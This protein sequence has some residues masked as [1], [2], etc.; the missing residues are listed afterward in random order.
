MTKFKKLLSMSVVMAQLMC[1][2]PSVSRAEVEQPTTIATDKEVAWQTNIGTAERGEEAFLYMSLNPDETI[3]LSSDDALATLKEKAD[4]QT[5]NGLRVSM[6]GARAKELQD[7]AYTSKNGYSVTDATGEY[8][9][10]YKVDADGKLGGFDVEGAA[11]KLW[12]WQD[13]NNYVPSFPVNEATADERPLAVS[14]NYQIQGTYDQTYN[15]TLFSLLGFNFYGDHYDYGV[16]QR[17]FTIEYHDGTSNKTK[18]IPIKGCTTEGLEH[19]VTLLFSPTP[20]NK[21]VQLLAVEHDG[22][23]TD[24]SEENV[25]G[26][27]NSYNGSAYQLDKIE[28]RM[29]TAT[30]AGTNYFMNYTDLVIKRGLDK[31]TFTA[32]IND[33]DEIGTEGF[34][35]TANM[36]LIK[37]TLENAI[38]VYDCSAVDEVLVDDP[39][40][41]VTYD[42][43][44]SQTANISFTK[45]GVNGSFRIEI[46]NVA[47]KWGL[48]NSEDYSLNF[49][50]PTVEP[51]VISTDYGNDNAVITSAGISI[52]ATNKLPSEGLDNAVKVY[53]MDFDGELVEEP[54]MVIVYSEDMLSAT[55]TF[56]KLEPSGNYKVVIKD[57]KDVWDQ[58][59]TEGLEILFK[60][61]AEASDGAD[62]GDSAP[63]KTGSATSVD[64]GAII[65]G[66][67]MLAGT[68]FSEAKLEEGV[69]T[70]TSDLDEW[71]YA[72]ANKYTKD[73][74]YW[75][76]D[77]DGNEVKFS[78][79]QDAY[80][81][82][83]FEVA[84]GETVGNGKPVVLSY[85]YQSNATGTYEWGQ[86]TIEALGFYVMAMGQS[87]E[88]SMYRC[89]TAGGLTHFMPKRSAT[90]DGWH[91]VKVIYAPCGYTDP[92]SNETR[93]VVQAIVLDGEV[94]PLDGVY[95][96][97]K[98]S[99]FATT[100][101]L[102]ID[103]LTISIPQNGTGER[104][105]KLRNLKVERAD[106][107]EGAVYAPAGTV[108]PTAPIKINFNYPIEEKLAASDIKIYEAGSDK[109]IENTI[110]V[111]QAYGKKQLVITVGDGGLYYSKEYK[112]VID[113]N[114][115]VNG[116]LKS[117]PSDNCYTLHTAE[118]PKVLKSISIERNSSDTSLID[119]EISGKEA[120]YYVA[121]ASYNEFGAMTGI[122]MELATTSGSD[123]RRKAEGDVEIP[124]IGTSQEAKTFIF[125]GNKSFEIYQMPKSFNL[126]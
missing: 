2:V 88:V 123:T 77:K 36:P 63:D 4:F 122:N 61:P 99:K 78:Y 94:F 93:A 107:L 35:I 64:V 106:A 83:D 116:Y 58:T 87:S 101:G 108:D 38:T 18:K 71:N 37:G 5:E 103:K 54:G 3:D 53:D 34:N 45:L 17:N 96:N 60:T 117:S 44:D 84:V 32:D 43:N 30:K 82:M 15:S 23:L 21:R 33:G 112:I 92:Q 52:Y 50:T 57:V 40:V 81:R 11:P 51:L 26:R 91:N 114:L 125:M 24:L 118:Y 111:E 48:P 12:Y 97:T 6:Y 31:Y 74:W 120:S 47:D 27:K 70:V 39:G 79:G 75:Y 62:N 28:T 90:E 72:W 67:S 95:G 69:Y 22:I 10:Y 102:Y 66:S 19:S 20:V 126:N 14:Y 13:R 113:R 56:T 105:M 86:P 73:N 65:K 76:T 110:T 7:V 49:L 121:V 16:A 42:D 124:E 41:V 29:R 1:L 115:V 8:K 59:F 100:D 109:P 9:Y 25:Y 98:D 85:D 68:V 104:T 80:G 55:L 119:Y 89:Y 46:K